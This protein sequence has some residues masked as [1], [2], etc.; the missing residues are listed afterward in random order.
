MA[1]EQV[2]KLSEF[3]GKVATDIKTGDLLPFLQKQNDN[4]FLNM[5]LSARSFIRAILTNDITFY[6]DAV[7]GNDNNDG[8]TS[9]TALA[10]WERFQYIVSNEIN[11]AW[12]ALNIVVSN[13]ASATYYLDVGYLQNVGAI[14]ATGFGSN[15]KLQKINT[16]A[17]YAYLP[18]NPLGSIAGA[19][20]T[21]AYTKNQTIATATLTQDT[22]LTLTMPDTDVNDSYTFEAHITAGATAPAITWQASVAISWIGGEQPAAEASKTNIFV[23]RKQGTGLIIG[24][25]GGAY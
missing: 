8:L 13:M 4:T 11:F 16:V 6:I 20:A 22:T 24:S 21:I 17:D 10:T 18:V 15:V 14:S 7:N 12:H 2:K 23:F 1:T 9:G 3:E 25:F 19:T 5:N